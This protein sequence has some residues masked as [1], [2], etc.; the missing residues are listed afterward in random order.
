MAYVDEQRR[1]VLYERAAEL[2]SEAPSDARLAFIRRTY[3][4]LAAA[5][6]AF[7]AVEAFLLLAT[8]LPGLMLGALQGGGQWSWLIV[9]GAFMGV[10]WLANSWAQS[11]A[12]RGMQYAGLGL[13]I[14]AQAIIFVP[15]LA[16]AAAVHPDAIWQAGLATVVLFTGLTAS[17]FL[18]RHDFSWLGPMLWIGGIAA[19]LFILVGAFTGYSESLYF[20]FICGMVFFAC[21][22]ILYDTSK[23]MHHYRTDQHVAAS[24][25]LFA[26]IALLFWYLVQLFMSRD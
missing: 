23:I 10:S 20:L 14:V 18:T 12:S 2:A 11:D 13:Y 19:L 22:W 25:A 4:H 15:L 1:G 26:S 3:L 6:L 7:V 24:L 5:V 9:L 17:V 8:P 16:I 21:A